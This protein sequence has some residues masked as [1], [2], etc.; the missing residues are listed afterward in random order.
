MK[1]MGGFGGFRI[2]GAMN[3]RHY[4]KAAYAS[5]AANETGSD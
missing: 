5:I 2:G 3:D 4:A 1:Q